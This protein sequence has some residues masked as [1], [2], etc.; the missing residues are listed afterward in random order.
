M[1]GKDGWKKTKTILIVTFIC[2]INVIPFTL[3]YTLN[4]SSIYVESTDS[5]QDKINESSNGDI[6]QINTSIL[7]S[8]YVIINK[9]IILQGKTGLSIM[10][11]GAEYGFNITTNNVT[12]RNIIINNCSTALFIKNLTSTIENISIY[13]VTIQNCSNQGIN[14]QNITSSS[15]SYSSINNCTSSAILLYNSTHCNVSK[16]FINQSSNTGLRIKQNSNNNQIYNNSFSNNSIS[17]N[18]TLSQNNTLYNNSFFNCTTIHA[19][20]DSSNNWNTSSHG[21]YWDDYTGT[22]SNDDN[23]GDYPYIITGNNNNDEKPLGF[24]VPIVNFSYEPISPSTANTITFTDNS[25]DPNYENTLHLNYAWDFDNNGIIDSTEEN[26]TYSYSDNG[27]YIVTLNITNAYQQWNRT[28]QTITVTNLGPTSSFSWNPNPVI[29]NQTATFQN[30][31][32]DSDGSIE[33]WYWDFGD[34]NTSTQQNPTH[35]YNIAGDYTVILNV[36][37]DDGN[38]STELQTVTVT[39]KP[40]VNFSINPSNPTTSDTITFS[41][42]ST[43]ADGSISD[44][45]WSFGDGTYSEN[46]NPTHSYSDDGEYSVTL[47]VTDNDGA[48]NH[49]TQSITILNTQP[50]ANFTYI[51]QNPTDLQ[52]LTFT[53]HSTDSDG[54]IV[55]CTWTFGDGDTNYS[56]N[57]TTHRYDDNGTF[58]VTLNVTDD[59]G[60]TDE[61]IIN[62]TVSNVGPT[63]GFSFEPSLPEV[64]ETIWFNDTSTDQDGTIVN[65]TWNFGDTSKD[66]S[67]NSNHSYSKLKSYDVTLTVIDN[68]GNSTSITK[69]LILK[70]TIIKSI[71]STEPIFYNLKDEADAQINI[72]TINTTNLTVTTYS[73]RPTNIDESISDYENLETYLEIS[74]ENDSLLEWINFSIYYSD[75]DISDDI[76]ESSLTLFYWNETIEEWVNISNC[77]VYETD[78]SSYSGYVQTNISHLTLFTLAGTLI[79]E[80]EETPPTLPTIV[81][82]SDNSIFDISTPTINITYNQMVP[83]LSATLNGTAIPWITNN[84]KTF[85]FFINNDLS[86]GNYTIQILIS[87]GSLSRTDSIHFTINISNKAQ[88][89]NKPIIIP[90]WIWYAIVFT[91][92]A[93][94]FWFF[95]LKTIILKILYKSKLPITD[96]A[97]ITKPKIPSQGIIKDTLFTLQHSINAI[98][99]LLFGSDDPWQETKAEI[100]QTMFNIDLFTE[101]PDVYVGIQE[102]ILTEEKTCKKIINL[103]K[104]DEK[105]L[106][107]IKEKTSL[108][109]KDLGRELSIL[110]KYGLI[111]EHQNTFELTDQ[112][113]ELIKEKRGK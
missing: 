88:T 33:S 107:V 24:F 26:P 79:Q 73:E 9:S 45:N 70:E 69:H 85:N 23:L 56:M 28:N 81:N 49:T 17:I 1:K 38:T 5:L 4:A 25:T 12:F 77:T 39:L 48:S 20:D 43:D 111:N 35:T 67:Q 59:D 8:D 32:T 91:I 3:T 14:L 47:N 54:H 65:W 99:P 36:T 30:T 83:S 97:D 37:D 6:I 10:I 52:T 86:N 50:T 55:N 15:I 84:N 96:S 58:I 63:A 42:D 106:E 68:D 100:N 112:A 108:S 109:S 51:P 34:G 31:S 94:A 75:S 89:S 46:Q 41:D 98:E 22:D 110:L 74:L 44:Y 92:I 57:S 2:L 82:S 105:S 104:Q 61:Y 21:N 62:I 71:G 27:T 103:L 95:D 29:V 13:N 11:D 76:D 80:E 102:K 87:N 7:L 113:K 18:I 19:F 90:L 64:G 40:L 101:K 72:K 53:N 66:H 60:D 93:I 16:N 78:T